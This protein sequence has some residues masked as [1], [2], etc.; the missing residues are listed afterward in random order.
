M[1]VFTHIQS[2]YYI[3]FPK[4]TVQLPNNQRNIDPDFL[5]SL[6]ESDE[7][8]AFETLFKLY[9]D[10][11][12]HIA[13]SY[14]IGHENAEEIVQNVFMK[15]W[16]RKK[17]LKKITNIN[18]YLYL[19]VRNACLDHI[20]HEKIKRSYSM[21]VWD[22]KSAIQYQFMKDEAAHLLLENELKKKISDSIDQLPEK[23]KNVFVKSRLLGIKHHE[24]AKLLGISKRT[25][26]A[27]IS[28]ALKQMRLDLKDF[29]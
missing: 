2:I 9:F 22:R 18:S 19:M 23:C 1:V 8:F 3:R 15:L 10:K 11:L 7:V 14:Q 13:R 5:A 24:I 25:V 28:N 27:H 17:K 16:V 29:I 6:L 4:P 20:K 21:D 12:I 26:D